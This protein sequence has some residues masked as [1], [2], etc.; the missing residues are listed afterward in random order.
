MSTL[1]L[2][3]KGGIPNQRLASGLIGALYLIPDVG[4]A[5]KIKDIRIPVG[6]DIDF[7]A[8]TLS[9]GKYMI[10]S[11]MPSGELLT[12]YAD[13]TT[14]S[15]QEVTFQLPADQEQA[16]FGWEDSVADV[17]KMTW[18]KLPHNWADNLFDVKPSPPAGDLDGQPA[19]TENLDSKAEDPHVQLWET[20]VQAEGNGDSYLQELIPSLKDSRKLLQET[21]GNINRQEPCY[22]D[23][24]IL[25]YRFAQ[26][27]HDLTPQSGRK[28]ALIHSGHKNLLLSLPLPWDVEEIAAVV[29]LTVK[30]SQPKASGSFSLVIKD[31]HLSIPLAY[32]ANDSVNRAAGTFDLPLA[33]ALLGEK[34]R[35]PLGA[36][37]GGYILLL[38]D[39]Q[40][41]DNEREQWHDWI[42]NL[43]NW[44]PRLPDGAIQYAWLKLDHQ[45]SKDDVQEARNALL[46][47]CHRGLPYYTKG[48]SLLV[49]GL[50]LFKAEGDVEAA[51]W[52]DKLLPLAWRTDM[53]QVFLTVTLADTTP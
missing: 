23:Q 32:L 24:D 48:L 49:D 37:L 33:Q 50:R 12:E 36:A 52:L 14:I 1:K 2:R 11:R 46:D 53:A 42:S 39:L 25:L 22:Q 40:K 26:S 20:S 30:R 51:A 6:L 5:K 4:P 3:M 41:K 15:E 16:L 47:A 28:Y 10:E 19:L 8:M 18:P 45:Q 7:E 13:L 34:V 27:R 31:P 29:E 9:P 43:K 44:F 17:T 21:A 35:N 38:S